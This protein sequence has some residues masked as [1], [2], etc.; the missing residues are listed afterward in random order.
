MAQALPKNQQ[1]TRKGLLIQMPNRQSSDDSAPK[2]EA[3]DQSNAE[4]QETSTL[5]SLVLIVFESLLTFLLRHDTPSQRL[6]ERLI[7]RHAVIRI[8]THLPAYT[9]YATFS[10]H[11]VLLDEQAPE[12]EYLATVDGS[13]PTFFRAFMTAPPEILDG[14]LIHG[15]D[16]LVAELRQLMTAF[17]ISNMLSNWLSFPW[18]GRAKPDQPPAKQQRVKPL[19]KRIDEQKKQIEQLNI[20]IKQQAHELQQLQF[21]HKM[22]LWSTAIGASLL[23]AVILLLLLR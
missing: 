19:L 10:H 6:A 13:I 17:N 20:T 18:F 12:T 14:I 15:E 9:F 21:Q 8:R 22:L 4:S 16:D 7:A 23:L 11:G 2:P 5:F 1:K 3:A